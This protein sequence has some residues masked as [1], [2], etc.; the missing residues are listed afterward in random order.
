M[1]YAN[2]IPNIW[3]SHELQKRFSIPTFFHCRVFANTN[4]QTDNEML[5]I[6]QIK[7]ANVVSK[8]VNN[9]AVGDFFIVSFLVT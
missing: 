8:K 6:P 1:D 4:F 9:G 2:S 7:D 5:R 3:D